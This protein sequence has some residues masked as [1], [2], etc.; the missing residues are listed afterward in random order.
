MTASP[1]CLLP[2]VAGSRTK[3]HANLFVPPERFILSLVAD[4]PK[5]QCNLA[6]L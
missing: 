6:V 5:G 4:N 2:A 3:T 1:R